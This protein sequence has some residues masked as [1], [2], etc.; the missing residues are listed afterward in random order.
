M[1]PQVVSEHVQQLLGSCGYMRKA[2]DLLYVIDVTFVT[3]QLFKGWLK[4]RAVS[5]TAE[6]AAA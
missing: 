2:Q 5:N 3:S 6:S 1:K 4:V